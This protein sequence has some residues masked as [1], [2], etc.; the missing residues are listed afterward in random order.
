MLR[1]QELQN[2]ETR[3]D[4]ELLESQTKEL[5]QL[6]NEKEY[7]AKALDSI[8]EELLDSKTLLQ[9]ERKRTEKE[10]EKLNKVITEN[11][12]VYQKEIE[13]LVSKVM[14]LNNEKCQLLN[15]NNKTKFDFNYLESQMPEFQE[16]IYKLESQ[17]E[18]LKKELELTKL[19]PLKTLSTNSRSEYEINQETAVQK[20][21][22][23]SC[24]GKVRL[25]VIIFTKNV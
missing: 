11:K 1:L 9:E 19:N 24:V 22:N 21:Q 8:Q 12:E 10:I 15:D 17:N 3:L 16:K 18:K 6:R 4:R 5:T 14:E 2:K 13:N 20:F 25:F 7:L 23:K